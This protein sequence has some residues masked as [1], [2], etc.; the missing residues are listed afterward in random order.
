LY[1]SLGF[2][3]TGEILEDEVVAQLEVTRTRRRA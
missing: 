1:T 2:R 3:E